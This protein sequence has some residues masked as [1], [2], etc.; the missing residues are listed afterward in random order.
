M[1]LEGEVRVYR[2]N[3]VTIRLLVNKENSV[4]TKVAAYL[5]DTLRGAGFGVEVIALA[6]DEYRAAIEARD[7]DLYLGEVSLPENMDI[8]AL[9]TSSVCNSGSTASYSSLKKSAANLLNGTVDVRTFVNEFHTALPLIPLYY[10]LD[11]LA[12]SMDVS[13]IFGSSVSSIYAGI[14]NWTF[15]Q[16]KYE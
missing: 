14:E 15:A 7:F 11:A 13:G 8:S 9:F 12:V 3:P 2:G 4:R 6:W 5:A 1:V 10:S 16:K